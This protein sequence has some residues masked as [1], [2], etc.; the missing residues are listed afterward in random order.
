MKID[1]SQ[2][3]LIIL[4]L[5]L[6][7]ATVHADD[8]L[9]A[10]RLFQQEDYAEAAEIYTNPAW[11]GVALYQSNQWWRAAEAFV[12]ADDHKSCLL[13]TSPSPRD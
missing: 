5:V 2:Q 13:Y 4:V 11:K 12:R 8:N 10:H 6:F 1:L 9:I 3:L 7:Q